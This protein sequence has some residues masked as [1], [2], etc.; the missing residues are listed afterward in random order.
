[1]VNWK[2]LIEAKTES[3]RLL[4]EDDDLYDPPQ[5]HDPA[6][7]EQIAGAEERLGT[8]LPGQYRELLG[9]TN[10][11]TNHTDSHSLLD[12]E[13]LGD[14]VW[15]PGNSVFLEDGTR[16]NPEL[17]TWLWRIDIRDAYWECGPY[18]RPKGGLGDW[19]Y[20]YPISFNDGAIDTLY[21]VAQ[22]PGESEPTE[23]LFDTHGADNL[24]FP[25]LVHYL[26][27]CTTGDYEYREYLAKQD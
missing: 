20:L 2:T 21:A 5:L 27:W 1:M 11:W 3:S 9:V 13:K 19:R 7:E 10:G 24:M 12:T 17:F 6:T 14:G 22:R 23:R 18:Q 8:R 15:V 4:R 26:E 25:T 16:P